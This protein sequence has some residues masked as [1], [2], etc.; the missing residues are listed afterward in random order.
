MS[1]SRITWDLLRGIGITTDELYKLQ[2]DVKQWVLH[3]NISVKHCLE[4]S[5]WPL[6][7]LKN[8]ELDLAD[9]AMQQ[10]TVEEM[11]RLQIGYT[12]LIKMG[13][14]PMNMGTLFKYNIVAWKQL[15]LTPQHLMDMNDRDS[16]LAFGLPQQQAIHLL[17]GI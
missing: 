11:A 8:F 7:P 5:Q 9:I 3:G 16:K 12:D 15:G 1:T 14:T 13:M 2:P 4:M 17:S 10:W 6:L